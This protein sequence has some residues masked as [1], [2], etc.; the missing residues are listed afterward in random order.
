MLWPWAGPPTLT[1]HRPTA[2]LVRGS[3]WK[4]R[5][6]YEFVVDEAQERVR[7]LRIPVGIGI[8]QGMPQQEE[9]RGRNE[10]PAAEGME[11]PA[12]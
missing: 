12:L 6:A 11:H 7:L 9:I 10:R 1:H 4:R 3:G 2:V 5:A 8:L